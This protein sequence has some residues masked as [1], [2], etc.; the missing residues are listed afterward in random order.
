MILTEETGV[1]PP[2]FHAWTVPLVEDMLHYART[3][4]TEA[5]VTDPVLFMGDILWERASVQ[6]SPGMPLSCLQQ[7]ACGLANQPI[8][9]QT[10]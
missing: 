8:L 1:V 6:M 7:W 10:P 5:V 4:L 9:P 2:L 3:G